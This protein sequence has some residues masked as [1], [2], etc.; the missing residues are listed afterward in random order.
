MNLIRA[1]HLLAMDMATLADLSK[2][3]G[4][5]EQARDFYKKAYELEKKAAIMT[6]P[7]DEDPDA[8]FILMRSAASLSLSAGL[9]NEGLQLIEGSLK[10]KP[11]LWMQNELKEVA[12]LIKN[13][14]KQT[15]NAQKATQL[16]GLLTDINSH[17]LEI[18]LQNDQLSRTFLVIVPKKIFSDI[19]KKYWLH[20]V[21]ISA[22]QS[23]QGLF[24]LDRIAAA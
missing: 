9:F 6:S 8:H 23:S 12:K 21:K 15:I 2:G 11:P 16:E 7:K 24:F 4:M 10:N 3:R 18:T 5:I 20:Q 13:E 14:K 19:V 22:F 1:T 17:D